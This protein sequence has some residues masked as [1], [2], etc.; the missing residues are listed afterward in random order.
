MEEQKAAL[1]SL[2]RLIKDI[3]GDKV[4]PALLRPSVCC[5]VC[6]AVFISSCRCL[7]AAYKADVFRCGPHCAAWFLLQHSGCSCR[8][9]PAVHRACS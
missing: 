5:P 6:F 3:L 1:E 8:C 9:P 2:C 7:P 4:R